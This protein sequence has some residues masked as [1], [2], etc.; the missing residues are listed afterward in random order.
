MASRFASSLALRT[1]RST[2]NLPQLASRRYASTATTGNEFVSERQHIKE[3]AAKSADL[4]RKL[5]LY[6][7]IPGSIVLG[8]YIY[9]IEAEHLKHVEHA[10][11]EN[12]NQVPERTVY[13]YNTIRKK[14][15]PWGDGSKSF[16]H[17]E[18]INQAAL[19]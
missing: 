15:F 6:L 14:G 3:H 13:E 11:H 4:W 5:S 10:Y 12:D 7:C 2:T 17:N 8:V 16:F 18:K 9:G 19:P 1:L